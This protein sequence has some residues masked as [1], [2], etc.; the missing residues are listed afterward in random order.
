MRAMVFESPGSGLRL[1]AHRDEPT[2]G[3]TE[4]L[5]HVRACAV[6]R[7]DLHILDGD[8]PA[9]R[10]PRIL[11]HQVVGVVA[12]MGN[13]ARGFRIGDRVGIPWLGW[14]CGVCPWCRS[15]RENL[16]DRAEFTGYGRDGGLAE[17]IVADAAFV[18]P[19]P[20]EF[21]DAEAAPLLCAGMIGFRALRLAGS[22]PRLGFY[23]FGAAAHLAI[24]VAR[25]RRQ[26]V[27]VFTRPGDLEGQRRATALGAR[28]AGGSDELPPEPLDAAVVFAPVGDLIPVALRATDKGGTVVCAGIH[29]SDIPAF[30][31]RILWEERTVRSVANLTRVDGREFLDVAKVAEIRAGTTRFA[32][33]DANEAVAA[34]RSG[35][36]DGS[37]VVVP[38]LPPSTHEGRGA[39][40][41]GPP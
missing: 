24:Q 34:V 22:G 35:R 30:P 14:A 12:A 31:Y 11:G 36:L 33:E 38:S 20:S 28:W 19:I 26:D 37:A 5:V 13:E 3:P 18:F 16:C 29:M 39:A 21:G 40:R 15:G 9:P 41:T 7:T 6:C 10:F 4:L 23:G 1:D 32:L 8:L 2:P 25:H 17:Q 27:F